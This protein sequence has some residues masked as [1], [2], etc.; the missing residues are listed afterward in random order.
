MPA[1]E[2]GPH[3]RTTNETRVQAGIEANV[4]EPRIIRITSIVFKILVFS[5][6]AIRT[7]GNVCACS[8]VWNS[9][10]W[11]DYLYERVFGIF[12]HLNAFYRSFF[13]VFRTVFSRNA[14]T[15]FYGY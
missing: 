4:F 14:S 10:L 3:R 7:Y 9:Y 11:H 8:P 13:R 2:K 1:H 5:R 15:S 12:F 6:R